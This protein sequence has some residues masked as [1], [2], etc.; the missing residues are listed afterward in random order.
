MEFIFNDSSLFEQYNDVD[1]FVDDLYT[2][3][4][5]ML[6]HLDQIGQKILK[7]YETYKQ[8]VTKHITLGETLN[9]KGRAE[10]TLV[11]SYLSN[12]SF[13]EPYWNDD[14]KTDDKADY[15]CTY[16]DSLP[17]CFTEAL[18]RNGSLISFKTEPFDT[19]K[20]MLLKNNIEHEIINNYDPDSFLENMLDKGI[21][22]ESYYLSNQGKSLKIL[23]YGN[24]GR[25]HIQ[26]F[27]D[28]NNL[29]KTDKDK[30]IEKIMLLLDHLINRTDPGT[31]CKCLGNGLWELRGE[32]SEQRAFRIF[33]IL[34]SKG[35]VFL[36]GF[37]KKTQETPQ[38]ELD[39]A[40]DIIKEIKKVNLAEDKVWEN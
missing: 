4:L 19:L 3:T 8:K 34:S 12:L 22:N 15:K 30:V 29:S 38:R 36:N 1:H 10:I 14:L 2:N 33:Y 26:E 31:L 17:N 11:K 39:I 21:I 18:E 37:I 27:F 7:G 23:L 35:I 40:R 20:L 9:I 6:K 24:K 32:L 16:N 28:Q 25:I 5:P 13:S